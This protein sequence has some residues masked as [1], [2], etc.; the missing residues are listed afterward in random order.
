MF[1]TISG[2]ASLRKEY[3]EAENRMKDAE[4]AMTVVFSRRKAI[5]AEKRQKKEQKAEAEKH[6]G[7]VAALESAKI[8]HALWQVYHLQED[9]KESKDR[10]RTL[11]SELEQAEA[12]VKAC[13]A[14][15]EAHR[16][17]QA[18]LAKERLLLDKQMGKKRAEVEKKNPSLVKTREKIAHTKRR[19]KS[20]EKEHEVAQG[21]A[22]EHVGKLANLQQQLTSLQ[23]AQL[24][25]DA[26][27]QKG[28]GRRMSLSPDLLN[29]YNEIKRGVG[30]K[31]AKQEAEKEALQANA[32]ADAEALRMLNDSVASIDERIKSLEESKAAD[33][34]RL[35]RANEAIEKSTTER[36]SKAEEQTKLQ[37]ERR[38]VEARRAKLERSLEETDGKLREAKADSKQSARE[39]SRRQLVQHLRTTYPSKVYGSVTDLADPTNDRYKLAMSVVLGKDFDSVIV[40]TPETAMQCIQVVKERRMPPMTFLP[41]E[42]IKVKEIDP[43]LRSMGGNVK[44]AI[45]CLQIKDE[46]CKRAYQSICGT[47]LLCDTVDQARQVAFGGEVRHKVIALDGTAFLKTGIIT[48]G[49]TSAMEQ[50]A[51]KWDSAEV[52]K[53]KEEKVKLSSQLID[54]PTLRELTE[55]LQAVEA[56][57]SRLDNSIHYASA[58][59][60]SMKQKVQE[61]VDQITN[62]KRERES[63]APGA[64]KLEAQIKE[65]GKKVEALQKSLDK[66]IEGTFAE[67]AK[68]VVYLVICLVIEV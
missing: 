60:K 1:E 42:T 51:S 52:G 5:A 45:D 68:Y 9:V 18:S 37:D 15:V 29:E 44:V 21:K 47:T 48:G 22:T 40:D 26:E 19:I 46:R 33:E 14:D 56:A 13:E 2:S 30:A 58:E 39:E 65:K 63:K 16:R 17:Q 25:V 59:Q 50:R 8:R 57:I 24:Q 55:K 28:R 41:A 36:V 31:T 53:L 67:F 54:L 49:I 38:R 20:A 23:D 62:L 64:A 61:H 27:L 3:D 43:G 4:S 35:T 7:L 34:A 11:S 10:R 12:A 66:I 6:M 32:D